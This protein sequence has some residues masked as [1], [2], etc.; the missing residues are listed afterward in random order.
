M[1]GQAVYL[2]RSLSLLNILNPNWIQ[3]G[4]F[5]LKWGQII[6]HFELSWASIEPK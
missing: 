1:A 5:S 3:F 6:G 4:Y 2:A